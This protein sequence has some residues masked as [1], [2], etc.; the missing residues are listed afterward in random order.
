[1]SAE[2][3][4]P[5]EVK[6]VRE[7][8]KTSFSIHKI[9]KDVLNGQIQ[10]MIDW[11]VNKKAEQKGLFFPENP[12]EHETRTFIYGQR[13]CEIHKG[14]IVLANTMWETHEDILERGEIPTNEYRVSAESFYLRNLPKV[15]IVRLNTVLLDEEIETLNKSC[16]L[17]SP[18]YEVIE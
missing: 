18:H 13:A 7:K 1:M 15:P 2:K 10:H 11:R 16:V 5:Q 6:S 4:S 8:V 3:I 9:F 14:R 17:L 12:D